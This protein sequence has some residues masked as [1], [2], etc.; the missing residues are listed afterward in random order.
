MKEI[1]TALN[2]LLPADEIEIGRCQ[3]MVDAGARDGMTSKNL[4]VF[5]C[6]LLNVVPAVAKQE[7][8]VDGMPFSETLRVL[9]ELKAIGN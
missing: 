9:A 4:F 7:L 5:L 1:Q 6:L 8:L 2:N 3:R